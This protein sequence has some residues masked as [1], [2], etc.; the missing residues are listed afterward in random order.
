M[1]GKETYQD[2]L[3]YDQK[4]AIELMPEKAYVVWLSTGKNIKIDADELE[5]FEAAAVSGKVAKVRQGYINPSFFV[6]VMLDYER[7]NRL[8][9]RQMEITRDNA[10]ARD[11]HI[12]EEKPIPTLSKLPNLTSQPNKYSRLAQKVPFLGQD[13]K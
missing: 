13:S 12:G 4:Q 3:T 2:R 9:T 6:T 10:N 7:L 1:N 5:I 8:R 11:L